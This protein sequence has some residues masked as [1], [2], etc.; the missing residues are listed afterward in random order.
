[1]TQE[2]RKELELFAAK[3]RR[4]IIEGVYSAKS[5][6]PGGS[7]SC[8]DII[9]YLYNR[10]LN[11][12]PDD[13]KAPDRDRF[14]LSKGHCAPALYAAL[15]LKG[16]F[17]INEMKNLR[18]VDSF[19][20]GHP[21]LGYIPGVDMSTG[22]L[23]QGISAATGMALAGK[24][25]KRPYNVFS[26]LG[27]GELE[28][29]QVWEAFMSAAHY[30]LDNLCAFVD[31]NGLQIDGKVEDV[32][33]VGD[34]KAKLMAFGWNAVEIDGHDFDQIEGAMKAFEENKGSGKPFFVVANTHKG[35]GVSYM[36][37]NASWHG[38]APKEEQ[39]NIACS[40][41]DSKIKELE[42]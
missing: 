41:L 26:V 27:D 1:M 42:G 5:G 38:S 37:D 2:E 25:D 22:S 7:L 40:E 18:K 31:H 19:L 3:M 4:W 32:M 13:P 36:I 23:G 11:V 30:K 34:I 6:H 35:M 24:L 15:G 9:T 14:V 17:D 16:F 29:G 28:E 20:Q 8:T 33:N 10:V 21:C 39:Y 12:N